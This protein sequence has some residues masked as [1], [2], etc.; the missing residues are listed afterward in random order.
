[1]ARWAWLFASVAIACARPVPQCPPVPACPSAAAPVAAAASSGAPVAQPLPAPTPKPPRQKP[2]AMLFDDGL[3]EAGF[4]SRGDAFALGLDGRALDELLAEAERTKSDALIVLKDGQVIAERYFGQ[5]RGPIE[6]MSITKS[7]TA[8]AVTML[9]ESGKLRSLDEPVAKFIPEF[10]KDKRSA[11]TV[12][13]LLTQTSGLAHGKDAKALNAQKDRTAYA[14]RARA[15]DEPGSAFSYNNEATQLLSVVVEKSAG[16]PIDAY[17]DEALFRPL[18][19]RGWQWDKDGGDN[20][21][22]YYGLALQARDLARIGQLLL[23]Q[24]S[25]QGR[26]VISKEGI[27]KLHAPSDRSPYYGLLWWIRYAR[28]VYELDPAVRV[29]GVELGPLAGK[30]HGSAEAFW[31]EAGARLS[32]PEREALSS[33]VAGGG[34]LTRERPDQPIGFYADGSLGQRLAIFPEAK[35]VVVRQRRRRPPAE[36]SE[37]LSFPTMLKLSAALTAG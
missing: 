21:Q 32:A 17:L 7:I 5:R 28:V 13:H 16:K 11:V 23:D 2:S 22:T 33:F 24:G 14:R 1:M 19:I 12:R 4:F 29:E 35:L 34:K 30:Q 26:Q 20:V 37:A 18:G 31:L 9:L 8:L 10:A 3:A 27:A 6:T 25:L 36:E 15:V